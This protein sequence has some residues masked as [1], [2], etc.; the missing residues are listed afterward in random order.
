MTKENNTQLH[1][2]FQGEVIIF[3]VKGTEY[4]YST[5]KNYL[6]SLMYRKIPYLYARPYDGGKPKALINI[7]N[8]TPGPVEPALH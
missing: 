2:Y 4:R 8:G 5:T 6:W 7:N 3:R 1:I